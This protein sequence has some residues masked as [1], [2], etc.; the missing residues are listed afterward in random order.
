L[1]WPVGSCLLIQVQRAITGQCTY[2]SAL[3]KND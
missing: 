1:F 2:L 3:E